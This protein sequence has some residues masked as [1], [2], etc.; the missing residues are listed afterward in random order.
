MVPI[1]LLTVGARFKSFS[2]AATFY[3]SLL[4]ISGDI[5]LEEEGPSLLPCIYWLVLRGHDS[6]DCWLLL[7]L[8]LRE[9]VRYLGVLTT[10][11]RLTT[12]GLLSTTLVEEIVL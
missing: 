11:S 8:E 12:I 6:C 5:S 9:A 7:L 2:I 10:F 1:C 3:R 4:V